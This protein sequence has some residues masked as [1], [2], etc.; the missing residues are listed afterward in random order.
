MDFYDAA[1]WP[2]IPHGSAAMLY[3]DRGYAAPADAPQQ[4]GLAAW[5]WITVTGNA[6]G[7]GAIDW[8]EGNPC[9]TPWHLASYVAGRK[10]MGCRARVYCQ[11]SL[12]SAALDA[13]AGALGGSLATY[14]GLLWWIPTLDGRRWT[15]AE[16]AADCAANWNAALP[17]DTLWA[18]Q[19][20]QIPALGPAAVADVS[21]LFGTW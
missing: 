5:R 15:A 6:K 16:L 12:L 4:L 10:A 20:D 2:S 11:R 8:E 14:P 19:F 1:R 7:A 18:C 17:I 13:L 9:F 3:L 21:Q